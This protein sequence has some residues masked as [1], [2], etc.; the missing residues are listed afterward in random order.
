MTRCSDSTVLLI[1][2]RHTLASKESPG[3]TLTAIIEAAD[4]ILTTIL[5]L[6]NLILSVLFRAINSSGFG[7]LIR[8]SQTIE[9]AGGSN[10]MRMK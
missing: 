4:T 2:T 3:I 9:V 8:G 6:A 7:D 5:L 10:W 1:V